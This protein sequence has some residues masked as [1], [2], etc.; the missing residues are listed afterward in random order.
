MVLLDVYGSLLYA[1]SRTIEKHLPDPSGVDTPAVVL[2]LRGRSTAGST[3]M[4]VIAGYADRVAA[5]GG[6]LFLSGV[7]GPVLETLERSGRI[8]LKE[9]V[10]V[11]E[12]DAI[13]G[14]SSEVA[15]QAAETWLDDHPGGGQP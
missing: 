2:R 14:H 4:V 10:T 7:S 12:A 9:K 1:G 6:H 3:A 11:F 5:A 13:V 8:D 15:Y